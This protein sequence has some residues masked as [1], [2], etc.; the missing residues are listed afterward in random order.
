MPSKGES[1]TLI[2]MNLKIIGPALAVILILGAGSFYFLSKQEKS[3]DSVVSPFAGQIT[4]VY[5]KMPSKSLKEYSDPSGFSFNYPDNLSLTKNEATGSGIYADLQLTS[6][7]VDGNLNL[8][9]QETKLASTEEW[10]KESKKV[11]IEGKQAQW[12]SLNS[13]SVEDKD[14]ILFAAVDQGVV[15]TMEVSYGGQKDFWQGV[16]DPIL[17]SFAF[18]SESSQD[19]GQASGSSAE[20]VVFEGEEIVE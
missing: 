20:D 9:I 7:E 11:G 6:K 8:K 15:F 16:S 12:G 14:G 19:T 2:L 17:S 1:A 3:P 4:P 5:E 18:S 13:Q 10:L